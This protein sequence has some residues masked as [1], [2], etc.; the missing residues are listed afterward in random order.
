MKYPTPKIAPALL[1][2]IALIVFTTSAALGSPVAV[3][4]QENP[5][6][7]ETTNGAFAPFS[8]GQSFTPTLPAIDASEFLLG[9]DDSTIV[10]RLRDS[11]AGADGLSGSIISQSLPV[12]VDLT[13]S[14]VFHFDFPARVSLM[15]G[16]P[17]VAE[18]LI[19]TGSL[20]VRHTQGDVYAGGQFLH[21]GFSPTVFSNTD[22][23]F[24]EGIHAVNGPTTFTL[25]GLGWALLGLRRVVSIVA[26]RGHCAGSVWEAMPKQ[27]KSG[28]HK[29]ER[30][31]ESVEFI[32]KACYESR[33]MFP[34]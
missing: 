6:P 30:S 33:V 19:T 34:S 12:L 15:P 24:A 17:Y 18:L 29:G 23:V 20:G 16:Q 3:V 31:L 28:Q 2:V 21:Q 1:S 5:G 14:H 32:G 22:L 11:V 27:T 7:F 10:V 9:G 8:F 13:G 4:D 25:V 26:Q